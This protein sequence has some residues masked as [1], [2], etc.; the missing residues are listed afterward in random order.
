[1]KA[2]LSTT[3]GGLVLKNPIVI[4]ASNLV[5]DPD[6]LVRLEEA[7]A[8]AMDAGSRTHLPAKLVCAATDAANTVSAA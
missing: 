8:A 6:N 7:G 3:Y 5:M 1:M 2:N 4:G